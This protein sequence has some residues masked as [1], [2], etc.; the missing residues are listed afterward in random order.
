MNPND[1][2]SGLR[3]KRNRSGLVAANILGIGVDALKP[4]AIVEWVVAAARAGESRVCCFATVHMIME[5]RRSVSYAR[6]LASADRVAPDGLPLVW[7]QHLYGLRDSQRT[8]GPD[9]AP[10]LWERC[11][12]EGLPVALYGAT[13]ETLD[14]LR[15]G[16]RL[17]F[18]ALQVVY[19]YSPPFR[20]LTVEED[21]QIVRD[22]KASGARMVF[23]ALGCPKQEMWCIQHRGRIP[24]VLLPV[25]AAFDFHAGTLRRAPKWLQRLGLEWL[26]R[27]TQEP[28]RLAK[29]Y[30][31][32]N[33]WFLLLVALQWLG[34]RRFTPTLPLESVS[35]SQ[36]I[37]A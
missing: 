24:A 3:L 27:L 8:T 1:S 34:I 20:S 15:D 21:E 37:S 19:A 17:Q 13:N 16:L 14:L 10:L 23:V 35:T 26:H 30:F 12:R 11:E 33:T 28:R 4:D 25:G 7:V 9:T 6:M 36:E 22:L 18:P 2:G 31:V 32:Y 5:A 29:R